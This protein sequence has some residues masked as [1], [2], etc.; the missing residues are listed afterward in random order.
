MHACHFLKPTLDGHYPSLGRTWSGHRLDIES[1]STMWSGSNLWLGNSLSSP[2][3]KSWG[4]MFY[5]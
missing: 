2:S 4:D 1:C 5:R 3:G